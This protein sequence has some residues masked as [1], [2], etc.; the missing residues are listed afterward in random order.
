MTDDVAAALRAGRLRVPRLIASDLD[1]TLLDSS[2]AL[3]SRSVSAFR[4][5]QA[6]GIDVVI[7]TARPPRW[8][9][10]LT[11]VIGD[12]GVAICSNGAYVYD[13]PARRVVSERLIVAEAVVGMVDALRQAIPGIAFA[14]ESAAG[15]GRE[16]S[17]ADPHV[18][19]P[20]T[21]VS[22]IGDL[23]DPLPGKLLARAPGLDEDA[24]L[25][26]VTEV[27]GESALVAF[28]G[29]GGLAEISAAGVTKAAVLSE[30]AAE[31]GVGPHQVWAF[32]DM[33]NDV[34]MLAW[35]GT[36]FAVANAHGE[37]LAVADHVVGSN[38]DDGVARTLELAIQHSQ[39]REPRTR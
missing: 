26:R 14:V 33:P 12:H 6:V 22:D 27:V 19:P 20:D 17:Y 24:F 37:V 34:P 21:Q 31:R 28:S 8:M 15:F 10:E 1:G 25:R 13:V 36:S 30:W 38:D 7:A 5:V 35:A 3:S 23:L 11:D 32:G 18:S 4:D 9:H 29:A 16:P 2:G 39:P